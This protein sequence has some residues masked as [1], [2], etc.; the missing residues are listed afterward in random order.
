MVCHYTSSRLEVDWKYLALPAV[1][2]A[3]SW[4]SESKQHKRVKTKNMRK[5]IRLRDS[6]VRTSSPYPCNHRCCFAASIH[7]YLRNYRQH[8]WDENNKHKT[9]IHVADLTI[10]GHG[11]KFSS[12]CTLVVHSSSKLGTVYR[13]CYKA[14]GVCVA[15]LRSV[16]FIHC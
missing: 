13:L 3:L 2:L 11:T 12:R 15:G 7:I 1:A 8:K 16:V 6:K 5:F 10:C 9:H 4:D 14:A